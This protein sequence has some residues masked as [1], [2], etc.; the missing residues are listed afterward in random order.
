MDG[1]QEHSSVFFYRSVFSLKR[2]V[3]S[4]GRICEE[5]RFGGPGF[6]AASAS[7]VVQIGRFSET[8]V[9]VTYAPAGRHPMHNLELSRVFVY[10]V[11]Y[12]VRLPKVKGCAV[13]RENEVGAHL[14]VVLHARIGLYRKKLFHHI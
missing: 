12:P 8:A 5:C 3:E 13:N 6:D 2:A 1:F 9:I 4:P 10:P 14:Q 11:V 7:T